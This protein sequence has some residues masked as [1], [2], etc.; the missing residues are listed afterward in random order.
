MKTDLE[1]RFPRDEGE[2]FMDWWK[3]A[4]HADALGDAAY[5]QKTPIG[6]MRRGKYVLIPP[7]WRGKVP[8]SNQIRKRQSKRRRRRELTRQ[9]TIAP[10]VFDDFA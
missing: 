9:E 2:D 1:K 10:S 7:E 6:R 5:G 8:N 3:R 4:W